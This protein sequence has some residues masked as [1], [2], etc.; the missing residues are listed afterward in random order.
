MVTDAGGRL[1]RS[2]SWRSREH[3]SRQSPSHALPLYY[4]TPSDLSH[5]SIASPRSH[6]HLSA[7]VSSLNSSPCLSCQPSC[8]CFL[9]FPPLSP[10]RQSPQATVCLP[11][12]SWT[13]AIFKEWECVRVCATVAVC[14]TSYYIRTAHWRLNQSWVWVVTAQLY[15]LRDPRSWFHT[16]TAYKTKKIIQWMPLQQASNNK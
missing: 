12:S 1:T 10:V 5:V 16:A 14:Q 13:C 8:C 11:D 7:L 9:S 6:H 15:L 3:Q 4:C 2:V